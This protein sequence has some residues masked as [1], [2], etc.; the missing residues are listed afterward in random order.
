MENNIIGSAFF[1]DPNTP[2]WQ[3]LATIDPVEILGAP[4]VLV[5]LTFPPR[6]KFVVIGVGS[7]AVNTDFGKTPESPKHVMVVDVLLPGVLP[8]DMYN[9]TLHPIRDLQ[10]DVVARSAINPAIYPV[11]TLP[12]W[13]KYVMLTGFIHPTE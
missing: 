1:G 5:K 11:E 6:P 7:I 4:V 2:P 9:R 10:M 8:D 13:A 3:P 12:V